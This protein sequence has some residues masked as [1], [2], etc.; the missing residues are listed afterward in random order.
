[1]NL[2]L[3]PIDLD[4]PKQLSWLHDFLARHHSTP[5]EIR[6]D[7]EE[8]KQEDWEDPESRV[9]GMLLPGEATDEVNDRGRQVHG[10]TLLL[11]LNGGTRS[12]AFALPSLDRP[13]GW[14]ELLNTAKPGSTATIRRPA[15]N[16]VAHSLILLGF[17]EASE[18]T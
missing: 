7:A 6:P 16:L 13:G 15:V 3:E 2:N 11:L 4:D 8:M 10:R 1:M 17:V 18:R 5:A 14:E 9:V 12:R